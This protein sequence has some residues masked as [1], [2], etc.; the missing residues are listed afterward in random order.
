MVVS[1]KV[2][3]NKFVSS[4]KYRL[5]VEPQ[6]ITIAT[7]QRALL[8]RFQHACSTSVH[9]CASCFRGFYFTVSLGLLF[10]RLLFFFFFFSFFTLCTWCCVLPVAA[11]NIRTSASTSSPD[12]NPLSRPASCARP[13]SANAFFACCFSAFFLPPP[14]SSLLAVSGCGRFLP[15]ADALDPAVATAGVRATAAVACSCCH[16]P[17]ELLWNLGG[18]LVPGGRLASPGCGGPLASSFDW[19]FAYSSSNGGEQRGISSANPG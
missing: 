8:G 5:C 13:S 4:S 9:E 14:S 11:N 6:L 18:G 1:P 10:L 2:S 17:P 3:R 19:N 15:P 16:V 7:R 12:S